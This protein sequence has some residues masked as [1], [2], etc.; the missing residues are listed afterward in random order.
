MEKLRE[1]VKLPA[2]MEMV[3]KKYARAAGGGHYI[4]PVSRGVGCTPFDRAGS[5]VALSTEV[6]KFS[7]R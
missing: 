4:T 3:L 1:M 5:L 6:K 7:E 2:K